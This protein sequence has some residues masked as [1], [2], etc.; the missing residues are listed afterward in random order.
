[1]ITSETTKI[2]SSSN[3]VDVII[4]YNTGFIDERN[5]YMAIQD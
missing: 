5:P 2:H 1:M 4:G 3:E